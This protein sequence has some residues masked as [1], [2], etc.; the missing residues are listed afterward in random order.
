MSKKN[1]ISTDDIPLDGEDTKIL[2]AYEPNFD[3]VFARG[4]LLSVSEDDPDTLQVGFWSSRDKDIE[5]DGDEV[6]TGYKLETEAVMTWRTAWRLRELL[7]VY[8]KEH[9]P[10]EYGNP[11]LEED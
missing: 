1:Q 7:D 6:G 9:A 3:R 5:L 10:S 11:E 4:S 8:I 2:T